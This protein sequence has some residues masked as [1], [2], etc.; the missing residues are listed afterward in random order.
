MKKENEPVTEPPGTPKQPI[1]PPVSKPDAS[2]PFD[3]HRQPVVPDPIKQ[4]DQGTQEA[5]VKETNVDP[6]HSSDHNP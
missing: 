2:R 6:V 3:P 1:V 4:N 5:P